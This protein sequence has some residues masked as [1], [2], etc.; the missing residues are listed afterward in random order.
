[1]GWATRVKC[2]LPRLSRYCSPIPLDCKSPAG[3]SGIALLMPIPSLVPVLLRVQG[4]LTQLLWA[5][6]TFP[7]G[8]AG[9]PCSISTGKSAVL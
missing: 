6:Q 3:T 2:L 8:A 9:S 1:M 4:H 5:P 7:V